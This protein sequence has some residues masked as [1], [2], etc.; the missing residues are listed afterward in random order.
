VE[1]RSDLIL[2][3][4]LIHDLTDSTADPAR[5]GTARPIRDQRFHQ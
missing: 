4:E 1:I 5:S 2:I 3:H